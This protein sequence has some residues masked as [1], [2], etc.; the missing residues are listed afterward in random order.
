MDLPDDEETFTLIKSETDEPGEQL[1]TYIQDVSEDICVTVP[2]FDH[3]Y[4]QK[5]KKLR[6]K[7]KLKI[8]H[9]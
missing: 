8:V 1:D 2:S 9:S 5:K 7:L 3:D 4:L 6:R